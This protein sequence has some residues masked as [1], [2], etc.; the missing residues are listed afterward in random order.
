MA[1]SNTARARRHKITG[2]SLAAQGSWSTPQKLD[3]L[4][5]SGILARWTFRGPATSTVT[6][7]DV[8]IYYGAGYTTSTDP[9]TVPDEDVAFE[10][11]A[12]TVAGS[13]TVAD[14]DY[15]IL[16]NHAGVVYDIRRTSDEMWVSIKSVTASSSDE[17]AV[18]TVEARETL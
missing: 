14:D 17:D 10:R 12:I 2:L 15:D 11:T 13:A 4:G 3:E 1:G 9:A 8:R 18:L 6:V 7:I 16:Q 5:E